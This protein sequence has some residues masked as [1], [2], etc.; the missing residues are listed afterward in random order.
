MVAS[1]SDWY[2]TG[3]R[4]GGSSSIEVTRAAEPQLLAQTCEQAAKSAGRW[5]PNFA[6]PATA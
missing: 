1:C 5:P 4:A 3:T 6:R 2:R